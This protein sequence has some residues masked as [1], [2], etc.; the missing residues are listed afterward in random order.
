MHLVPTPSLPDA[1]PC[2]PL[3]S[4][5]TEAHLSSPP[6]F[7]ADIGGVL[8]RRAMDLQ[9]Q[10]WIIH[11]VCFTD[12]MIKRAACMGVRTVL[13]GDT[14]ELPLGT[15]WY[16]TAVLDVAHCRD[17]S[18]AISELIRICRPGARAV[19]VAPTPSTADL[20]RM[21]LISGDFPEAVIES[22]VDGQ[23]CLRIIA[24]DAGMP[25]TSME[26]TNC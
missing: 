20:L 9:R 19:I 17:S 4:D 14:D 5:F 8:S 23:I 22:E 12:L 3:A 16:N 7:V 1:A 13:R 6:G 25:F 11:A 10:G 24:K 26:G 2:G 15:G 18:T 21:P